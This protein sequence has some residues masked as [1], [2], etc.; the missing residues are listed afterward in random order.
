MLEDDA[1]S[2]ILLLKGSGD[3][4]IP[5]DSSSIESETKWLCEKCGVPLHPGKCDV[6]YR[7]AVTVS[8]CPTKFLFKSRH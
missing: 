8:L 2:K 1:I 4:L 3:D 6:Q 5:S 7:T